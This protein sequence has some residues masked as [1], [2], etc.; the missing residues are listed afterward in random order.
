MKIKEDE[1]REKYFDLAREQKKLRNMR[2]TVISVVTGALETVP[3][4]LEWAQEELENGGQI[5]TSQS[6][7]LFKSSIIRERV[8]ET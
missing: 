6:T 8:L 3:K 2:V 7:A 1:K 5:D 4:S